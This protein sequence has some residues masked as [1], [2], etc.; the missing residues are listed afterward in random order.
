MH[1]HTNSAYKHETLDTS[2]EQVRLFRL[3]EQS[4][5]KEP[6]IYGT[7]ETFDLA[8][9]PPYL[10]LSY[11]WGQ[12][13]NAQTIYIDN[14]PFDIWPNLYNFIHTFATTK[15]D[16]F[17]K[18]YAYYSISHASPVLAYLWIDQLC[19]DQSA[20]SE[21]NHQIGLMR[22]VY[23]RA[24]QVIAWLGGNEPEIMSSL[25][26]LRDAERTHS[27][28]AVQ[29]FLSQIGK[30][31]YWQ[32]LWIIQ[33]IVLSQALVVQCGPSYVRWE[34]ILK[35]FPRISDFWHGAMRDIVEQCIIK[36]LTPDL[37]F[38]DVI[39]SFSRQLCS[40][41]RDKIYGLLGLVSVEQNV[42]LDIDYAKSIQTVFMDTIRC[43]IGVEIRSSSRN[44]AHADPARMP[45]WLIHFSSE[46]ALSLGI[47]LQAHHEWRSLDD[48]DSIDDND[49]IEMP[50][51][52]SSVFDARVLW[53]Q[54]K[55]AHAAS[56][57]SF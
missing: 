4:G 23:S 2:R 10:A 53:R 29:H 12:P 43:V 5:V 25:D 7:L 22:E 19:I 9:C 57:R 15:D 44:A 27:T 20:V 35:H 56:S 39:G 1:V 52:P 8:E 38:R 46:L 13:L 55:Q 54:Q 11:T 3:T 40:D 18:M 34:V 6:T 17:H 33:E 50:I 49:S 32:R 51:L 36:G 28:S 42:N 45:E 30:H 31:Q 26:H 48:S 24:D 41:R 21:R 37:G 14:M 16:Q 47:R